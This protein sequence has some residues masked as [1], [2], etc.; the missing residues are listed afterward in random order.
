MTTEAEIEERTA[1]AWTQDRQTDTRAI[2]TA[3]A[4]AQ[5]TGGHSDISTFPMHDA[6]RATGQM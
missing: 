4:S 6:L 3:A 1:A 2:Q 5:L